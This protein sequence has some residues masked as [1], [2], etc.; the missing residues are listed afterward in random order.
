MVPPVS[1]PVCMPSSFLAFSAPTYPEGGRVFV[2]PLHYVPA[3]DTLVP[4]LNTTTVL[5]SSEKVCVWGGGGV[6]PQPLTHLI[7]S[8]PALALIL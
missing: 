2:L 6:E 5:V 4:D 3:G 7:T 8:L 1:P